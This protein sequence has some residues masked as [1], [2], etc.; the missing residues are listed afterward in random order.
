MQ[1]CAMSCK[2]MPYCTA[3]CVTVCRVAQRCATVC[4]T[5]QYYATWCNIVQKSIPKRSWEKLWGTQNRVQIGS[6]TLLGRPVASKSVPKASQE[7]SGTSAARPGSARR[8]PK[9]APGRQKRRLGGSGSLS[10][11]PKSMPSQ[12]RNRKNLFFRA[13]L[14]REA[15]S[16]RSRTN[17]GRLSVWLQSLRTLESTAPASK[18]KGSALSGASPVAHAMQLQK[19]A[20]IDHQTSNLA[21]F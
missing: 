1:F 21:Q 16:E 13:R 7:R 10:R 5:G 15:V 17:F 12:A 3:V 9:G 4:N 6:R 18:N 20:K 8:V 19:T 2:I 14:V 11:R